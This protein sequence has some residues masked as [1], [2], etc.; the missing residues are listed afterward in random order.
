MSRIDLFL[1]VIGAVLNSIYNRFLQ[2]LNHMDLWGEVLDTHCKSK[3]FS[4][5]KQFVLNFPIPPLVIV[6]TTFYIAR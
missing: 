2:D 6:L 1:S 3:G 4:F 5:R